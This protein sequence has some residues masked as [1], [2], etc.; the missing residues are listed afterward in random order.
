LNPLIERALSLSLLVVGTTALAATSVQDAAAMVYA[1]L[2]AV[3]SRTG[4][5]AIKY[6][7]AGAMSREN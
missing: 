7:P 1:G 5:E 6:P 2:E 4:R 3:Y